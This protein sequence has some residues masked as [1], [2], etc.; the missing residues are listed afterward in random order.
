MKS[1]RILLLLLLCGLLLTGCD[2]R[3]RKSSE[4]FISNVTWNRETQQPVPQ[5][6][7]VPA[8]SGI[9]LPE[10]PFSSDRIKVL[11]NASGTWDLAIEP[12]EYSYQI[13]M[14]DL[15]GA[16]AVGCNMEI[17]ANFGAPARASLEAM[18]RHD[19]PEVAVVS[20]VSYE[21]NGVLT[22]RMD[23]RDVDGSTY[24]A[25]YT[26]SASK[27]ER[28]SVSDFL[29][30]AGLGRRNFQEMYNE[31]VERRFEMEYRTTAASQGSY[32][33]ALTMTLARA[34]AVDESYLHLTEDG[35]L[36]AAAELISPSGGSEWVELSLP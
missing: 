29:Q 15:P 8:N 9:G 20:F 31:A 27:G 10:D 18:G 11:L 24:Q 30:A 17:E 36:I 19:A 3:N 13:P 5:T 35:K 6:D 1:A 12:I 23:R 21:H 26:V 32:D 25:Y 34:A 16:Q 28:V 4:E 14:L 33:A 22:V 7:P 2:L